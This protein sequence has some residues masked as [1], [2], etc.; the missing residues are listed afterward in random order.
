LNQIESIRFKVPSAASRIL[1]RMR[2]S[3]PTPGATAGL[4]EQIRSLAKNKS[5]ASAVEFAFVAPLFI[6]LV[7]GMIA[8]GVYFGAAHS[9]QQIAA[10][11]ARTAV[12]GVDDSERV[13]LVDEYIKDNAQSY[14][15][16]DL[17]RLKYTVGGNG[18][19]ASELIVSV[20]Y[21]AS[22]LPI[23]NIFPGIAM[24]GSTI[25][26]STSIRIGGL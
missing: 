20:K 26:R 14:S 3:V 12:A 5:G 6:L 7:L 2:S 21:D 23:W 19:D 13:A 9:V 22:S 18:K 16:I 8:Y 11:A 1:S 4:R 24:P 25:V 17:K 10:D 15:F